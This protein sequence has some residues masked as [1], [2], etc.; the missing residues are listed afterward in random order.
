[1]SAYGPYVPGHARL[2]ADTQTRPIMEINKLNT[3]SKR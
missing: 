1:M 3:I 2:Y